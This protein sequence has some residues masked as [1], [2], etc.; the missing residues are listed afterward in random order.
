MKTG[1]ETRRFFVESLE[2]ESVELS[3]GETH[4]ALDVLRLTDGAEVEVFDGSGSAAD[5]I[6]HQPG[7]KQVEV[8]I[9]HRQKA[10][11]RTEPVVE[12]AFAVPKGKRL[13]WLVEKAT[14]LGAARLSPVLFEHSVV[15]PGKQSL[16]RRRQTCIAAA[17]QC[18]NDFLPE[19]APAKTLTDFLAASDADI[20]IL[21]HAESN[22]GVPAVLK[23]WSPGRRIA[24][25]IGPEG[26]LT[27]DEIAAANKVGFLSVRVGNLTL[28]IETAVVAILAAVNACCQK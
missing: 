9:L 3:A 5:G 17:K 2:G 1:R 6:L 11:N 21:G 27:A 20:R 10:K 13:D 12:L 28:R 4:H 8:R 25:L 19:I 18:R 15:K 7:R 24:I 16:T 26:G 23:E 22:L 14:E